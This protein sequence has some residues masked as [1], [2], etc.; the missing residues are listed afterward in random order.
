[1]PRSIAVVDAETDP[2]KYGRVPV[3]FIWGFYNGHTYKTFETTD[4]LVAFLY[5]QRII[6]YAHN[7]GKF[8]YHFMFRHIC[9]FDELKII[10]GRLAKFTIGLCEFRDSFNILP[11]PLADYKKDEIDYSIMEEGERDKPKNRKKILAYLES[12]CRYLY[13]MVSGFVETYGMHLTQATAAMKYWQKSE[14]VKAPHTDA[15]YYAEL[16]PFYYGGRVE[17]FEQGLINEPFKVA[18]INSAY[19]YAMLSQH[20]IG[21]EFDFLTG[22]LLNEHL[23]CIV[24]NY[25]Y[26]VDAVAKGCFPYRKKDNSL[27]FPNDQ[28]KR[29]YKITGWEFRA[30]LDTGTITDWECVECL[31]HYEF[32]DFANYI[33]YFYDKRKEAKANDDKENDLFS[34]LLMNSLYGK[35]GSN[36]ENYAEYMAMA[37]NLIDNFDQIKLGAGVTDDYVFSGMMHEQLALLSKDLPE[38]DR[39]YYNVATSASITGF[40]RAYLWRAICKSKGIIYCDTDSIAAQSFALDIGKELGEWDIEGDFQNGAVAGKKLYAFKYTDACFKKLAEKDEA[41][42][43]WKIASKGVRLDHKQIVHIAQGGE[44]LYKPDAP[45]FS[46]HRPPVFTP[47][48]VRMIT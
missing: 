42:K 31:Y 45:T 1:M 17:C 32:T 3:P 22:E 12:D 44:I 10:N 15:E 21:T 2:F 35:F 20:P 24:G 39:R 23:A 28:E 16:K 5:D 47:R 7:G 18:D 25:F 8:D 41:Q 13:D 27:W 4:E 9:P 43:K 30:A 11:V 36:P 6:V 34:K 38:E 37:P 14:Q 40:V 26:T 33:N 48:T 29:R 46:V 19:P